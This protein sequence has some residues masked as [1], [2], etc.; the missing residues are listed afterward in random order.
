MAT[1]SFAKF[2][3]LIFSIVSIS[4]YLMYAQEI[5]QCGFDQLLEEELKAR[6][7]S[8]N[9]YANEYQSVIDKYR[10]RLASREGRALDSKIYKMPVVF[11]IFY[12]AG[13]TPGQGN[14][15]STSL[16]EGAVKKMNDA[17]NPIKRNVQRNVPAIY[18]DI[19]AGD[20]GI[21]FF[22]AQ[23]DPDGFPT[24]GI[25]R[26]QVPPGARFTANIRTRNFHEFSKE[27]DN[28]RYLNIWVTN[29]D[30]QNTSPRQLGYST[31]PAVDVGSLTLGF[32]NPNT[33]VYR[34]YRYNEEVHESPY[35]IRPYTGPYITSSLVNNQSGVL[36]HELGHYFGLFH[37][38]HQGDCSRP[39]DFCDDTPFMP[40]RVTEGDCTRHTYSC[41]SRDMIENWMA[42]S[43]DLCYSLFTKC[44][45]E[46][47]RTACE[48]SEVG[49][50][51]IAPDSVI[52]AIKPRPND[53]GLIRFNMLNLNRN[54]GA[55]TATIQAGNYGESDITSCQIDVF[56]DDVK[57]S[58]S[59]PCPTNPFVKFDG[60]R[61]IRGEKETGL[62]EINLSGINIS[63]GVH[64][65]TLRVVTVNGSSGD[66]YPSNDELKTQLFRAI[67]TTDLSGENFNNEL[68]ANFAFIGPQSIY[69]V[70]ESVGDE[71]GNMLM[72]D[73]MGSPKNTRFHT[74]ELYSPKYLFP[75]DPDDPADPADPADANSNEYLELSFRYNFQ[76]PADTSVSS[77]DV[78]TYFTP[79]GND[80]T[81]N[82]FNR[83][84][85]NIG[86]DMY[87]AAH[88]GRLRPGQKPRYA[89][90][91][92]TVNIPL[93]I[94]S[95]KS[96]GEGVRISIL[97]GRN[98]RLYIDD[99]KIQK[100]TKQS[101][102]LQSTFIAPSLVCD[103][104]I[105]NNYFF[106]AWNINNL[107]TT[108]IP[109]SNY[110]IYTA[111]LPSTNPNTI[112]NN[113]VFPREN[114]F[115]AL[116]IRGSNHYYAGSTPVISGGA[117]IISRT[118]LHAMQIDVRQTSR[119]DENSENN[120]DTAYVYYTRTIARFPTNAETF[121]NTTSSA[122]RWH[123]A[124]SRDADKDWQ[125][126]T[127]YAKASFYNSSHTGK[128]YKLISPIY[129]G[130]QLADIEELA[131]SFKVAYA[132]RSDATKADRLQLVA[133]TECIPTPADILYEKA[134]QELSTQASDSEWTPQSDTHWRTETVDL[135]AF[136]GQNKDLILMFV[137]TN[138]GGNNLYI[139]DIEFNHTALPT[140]I[141]E[142]QNEFKVYP[143]PVNPEQTLYV[144][145]PSS[146]KQNVNISI[147][148]VSGKK[149]LDRV[150]EVRSENQRIEITFPPTESTY[151]KSHMYIL[152][153]KGETLEHYVRFVRR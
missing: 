121:E 88:S 20:M 18:A 54:T 152:H 39:T 85:T 87:T 130:E 81:Q 119:V 63:E 117:P 46:R 34:G 96:T 114:L 40:R 62:A 58:S 48:Y 131:I 90:D 67:S 24:N 12:E 129:S 15:L 97:N 4:N 141:T 94:G 80:V 144:E 74:F 45:R 27:W 136:T 113:H 41:G 6:G 23:R 2:T 82:D 52:T 140:P 92:R 107:G 153:V 47:A 102:D 109:R 25:V 49:L 139:D 142:E 68:P 91:W 99:F 10:H 1:K 9:V 134:G 22:L 118:G 128:A 105:T 143:N 69:K 35:D 145:L 33:E 135:E 116:S 70:A 100:K 36:P 127:K 76:G 151:F 132:H 112:P 42:Y 28:S 84:Y 79:L 106:I 73:L 71:G 147:V 126:S 148:D 89:D 150:Y 93:H 138:E 115:P 64:E 55:L 123:P 8:L 13:D 108:D 51:G 110:A 95:E 37:P 50:P 77:L 16:I 65:L 124:T 57:Q 104:F 31:F 72:I 56:I 44:Q 17:Y 38:F 86:I 103:N 66:A 101:I 29:I 120:I 19:D 59:L 21:E 14:N 26:V 75:D 111:I 149:I 3:L 5:S 137:A 53:L 133:F 43:P 98:G 7:V 32:L 11:H 30:Y 146:Q 122:F 60:N 83:Y 78:D 61:N 125:R